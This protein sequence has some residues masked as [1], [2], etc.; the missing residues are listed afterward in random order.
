[1]NSGHIS[2]EHR[3]EIQQIRS[4]SLDLKDCKLNK[5]AHCPIFCQ[6]F[7]DGCCVG[8][9]KPVPDQPKCYFDES[10]KFKLAYI[11]AIIIILF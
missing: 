4:L 10:Y 9:T 3:S 5:G 7:V 6:I 1:M 11:I 8:R 2:P